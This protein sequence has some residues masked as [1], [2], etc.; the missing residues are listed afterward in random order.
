[1]ERRTLGQ[2]ALGA[3]AAAV[4]M[5]ALSGYTVDD[6]LIT[7]RVATRLAHGEG[8]RFNTGGPR[9][10]AVTPLGYA[11]LLALVAGATPLETLARARLLGAL[12]WLL[13]A[14]GLGVGLARVGRGSAEPGALRFAPLLALALSAPLGAWAVSGMETGWVTALAT[15]ALL[16]G[17]GGWLAA[18]LAA[19]WRPELLPWA[20][21][22][23]V[24]SALVARA[25]PARVLAAASLA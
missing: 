25:P 9:V 1:M 4:M 15:A 20:L 12:A 11:N 17:S 24:G 2:A 21:T 7:A 18:G 16:P 13:A 19:A 5:L 10:D 23:A 6:A 14:A 8:Y 22:L 3:L